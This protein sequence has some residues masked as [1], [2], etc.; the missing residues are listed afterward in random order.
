MGRAE[1]AM[2]SMFCDSMGE[3][4]G[5]NIID[6]GYRD[7]GIETGYSRHRRLE[8]EEMGIVLD[9]MEKAWDARYGDGSFRRKDYEA[10]WQN[11]NGGNGHEKPAAVDTSNIEYVSLLPSALGLAEGASS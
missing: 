9:N 11:G 2:F 5:K 10:L 8:E 6:K 3:L 7:A 4:D 1:R